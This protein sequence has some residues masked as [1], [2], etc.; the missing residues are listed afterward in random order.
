[1]LADQQ[2]PVDQP[3]S[4]PT[5][6]CAKGRRGNPSEIVEDLFLPR[7][8]PWLIGDGNITPFLEIKIKISIY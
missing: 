8:V 5:D 4:Y 6:R 3:Y 1:V 7:R 2:A